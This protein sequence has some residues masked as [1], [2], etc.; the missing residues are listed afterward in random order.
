MQTADAPE[1][2]FVV[3]LRESGELLRACD[4]CRFTASWKEAVGGGNEPFASAAFLYLPPQ[5][6]LKEVLENTPLDLRFSL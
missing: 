6:Q 1:A 5:K 4:V 3:Q 2:I